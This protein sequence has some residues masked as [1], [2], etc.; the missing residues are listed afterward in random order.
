[1]VHN[2]LEVILKPFFR[3]FEVKGGTTG[4]MKGL[5]LYLNEEHVDFAV[6]FNA[7]FAIMRLKVFA[8]QDS[9]A[10]AR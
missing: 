10:G 8:G 6:R 7:D 1:M 3:F 4:S 9:G 2:G 5:H